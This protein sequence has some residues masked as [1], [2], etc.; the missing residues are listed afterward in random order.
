LITIKRTD[1]HNLDFQ[2]LVKALDE[3]LKVYY[4]EEV[5]FYD[6]LNSLKDIEYAVVAYNKK[7]NL[8]G[9]GAI[10]KYSR[11][12]AEIKRMFVPSIFRGKGIATQILKE[13]ENWSRE[14][15]FKKTIL[16]TLKEKQYAIQFY[17]K[18]EYQEISNFGNYITAEN[19]ICFAKQL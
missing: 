15:N 12:E 11:E 16:E 18:N 6:T 14:L 19:S 9:C 3:S 1:T 8:V 13:L 17:K 5:S 4:K 10:K 7:E 2:K